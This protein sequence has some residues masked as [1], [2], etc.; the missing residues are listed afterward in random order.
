LA[1]LRRDADHVR[2]LLPHLERPA[3]IHRLRFER[4]A[5]ARGT[6]PQPAA[7][8]VPTYQQYWIFFWNIIRHQ[9]LGYSFQN[10]ASVRWIVAQDAP[11]T[12]SV[13]L[14]GAFIWMLIS[15][16]VGIISALRPRSLF[17]RFS[18]VF[19]L[20]GISASPIWLGL[21]LTYTFGFKL[22]GLR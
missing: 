15:I 8:D 20:I 18:M 14:G 19:V 16:P 17:D 4:V 10:G 6:G 11:V 5:G 1:L 7:P 2:D 21:M 3:P 13:V 9:S 22:A 12:A